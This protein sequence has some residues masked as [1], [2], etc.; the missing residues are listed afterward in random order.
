[1]V[2]KGYEL[3]AAAADLLSVP[4]YGAGSLALHRAVFALTPPDHRALV[5]A[6]TVASIVSLLFLPA[7]LSLALQ[8]WRG[9]GAAVVVA[10][11]GLAL[12]PQLVVDARSES[13]LTLAVAVL[14]IGWI[15]FARWWQGPRRPSGL[16]VAALAVAL[17]ATI[18]PEVL[19]LGPMWLCCHALIRWSERPSLEPRH[20]SQLAWAV[21]AI[22]ALLLPHVLHLRATTAEQV[23]TGALPPLDGRALLRTVGVVFGGSALF[24][25]AIFPT[26][27]FALLA[28]ALLP[29]GR[30]RLPR[31]VWG[32]LGLALAATGLV[33]IDLPDVS[34]PRLHAAAA[35]IAVLGLAPA[36]VVCF[37][38]LAQSTKPP[39]ALLLLVV[40]AT[41]AALP[42]AQAR[43]ATT[44][45]DAEEAL[46]R[47]AE[48]RMPPSGGCL[49]R[50]DD[51][52][53]P[54]QRLHRHFPDYRFLPPVRDAR[55]L[56]LRAATDAAALAACRRVVAVLGTRCWLRTAGDPERGTILPIC[57]AV[58]Q[59]PGAR[60]VETMQ[61]PVL[62][63]D[64]F[65]WAPERPEWTLRLVE[66]TP[67]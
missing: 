39:V 54:Q 26:A 45:E 24:R 44:D 20:R 43:T 37:E 65:G 14:A 34:L 19:V 7:G 30:D 15:A 11:W 55:V 49:L 59:R 46:A 8:S 5:A 4:R 50:L 48:A 21:A 40:A 63:T 17:A 53:P 51:G 3:T 25:T 35:A 22:V 56:P 23:A 58:T 10:A 64:G 31:A 36:A 60:V 32:M 38:R 2:Y 57:G 29:S 16:A 67:P 41:A 28:V 61:L 1:M 6:H 9:R 42:S 13:I 47:R 12:L 33:A 62:A 18:R 27:W 66:W 52:D